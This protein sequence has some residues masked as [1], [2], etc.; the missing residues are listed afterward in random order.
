MKSAGPDSF[1]SSLSRPQST[2][3]SS[4][5]LTLLHP[6]LLPR[7]LPPPG[8][9]PVTLIL[10]PL[11]IPSSPTI[12]DPVVPCPCDPLRAQSLKAL[13]PTPPPPPLPPAVPCSRTRPCTRCTDAGHDCLEYDS[14]RLPPPATSPGP[15]VRY[16][17]VRGPRT[18]LHKPSLTLWRPDL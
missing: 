15:H 7:H 3:L 14:P 2:L 9:S 4:R 16:T 12:H 18:C 17:Q 5:T 10:H 13:K 8:Q 1:S 6:Q 11:I